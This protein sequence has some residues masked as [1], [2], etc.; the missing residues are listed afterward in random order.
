MSMLRVIEVPFVFSRSRA[1]CPPWQ[2]GAG[3]TLRLPP[4]PCL[5]SQEA[6]DDFK[7]Q[8]A[9]VKPHLNHEKHIETTCG[10]KTGSCLQRVG[11]TWNIMKSESDE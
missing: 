2:R 9:T 8:P 4:A 3:V 6:M 1:K 5:P 10:K 7:F 11:C